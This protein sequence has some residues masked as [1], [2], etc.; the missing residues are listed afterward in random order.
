MS[1]KDE[2]NATVE[3]NFT[4]TLTD[5]FEDADG[6]G[7]SDEASFGTDPANPSDKRGSMTGCLAIGHWT[8]IPAIIT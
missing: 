7:F 8:G 4:I 6:D 1:A 3:G 2:F 5:V